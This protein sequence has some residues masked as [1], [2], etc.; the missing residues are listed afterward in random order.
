VTTEKD[1]VKLTPELRAQL[2]GAPLV[3]ARLEAVFLNPED[4]VREL[5]ARLT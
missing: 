4:V 1:A 5:E 2:G 3:V